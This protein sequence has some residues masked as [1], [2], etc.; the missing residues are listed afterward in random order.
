MIYLYD[1]AIVDDL[2]ESFNDDAQNNPVVKVVGPE[3]ILELAAQI[4]NDEIQLPVVALSRDTPV[5]VDESRMNFTRAHKG[6]PVVMDTETNQ[7]FYERAIPINLS[8]KL[9]VLTSNQADMDEMMRELWFKYLSMYY[10]TI[11]L[12]YEGQ[13]YIRFGVA[14]DSRTQIEQS[15]GAL[16]YLESGTLYQS[17]IPLYCQGCVEVTYTPRH[18][19]R[20]THQMVLTDPKPKN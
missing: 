13:R 20:L 12:P 9:T 16:E 10:L 8:Y 19:T 6:V 2:S 7:I 1:N 3:H 15:S 5:E 14:I 18:L 17:I 4:Q 11:K